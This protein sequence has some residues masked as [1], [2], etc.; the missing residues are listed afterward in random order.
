M[1]LNL[2]GSIG[3]ERT[4]EGRLRVIDT[5]IGTVDEFALSDDHWIWLDALLAGDTEL[6]EEAARDFVDAGIAVTVTDWSSALGSAAATLDRPIRYLDDRGSIDT[7]HAIKTLRDAHVVLIGAGGLGSRVA[8]SLAQCGIGHLTIID[9]D[10]VNAANLAVSA[11]YSASTVGQRKADSLAAFIASLDLGCQVDTA[12]ERITGPADLQPYA[13]GADLVIAAAN[14]PSA[15]TV[16][17]TV[18][19]A[20]AA[21]STAH[22]I[23]CG[24]GHAHSFFGMAVLPGTAP[25]WMCTQ[26]GVDDSTPLWGPNQIAGVWPPAPAFAAAAITTAACQ[27]LL[28]E[29]T[30]LQ[31]ALTAMD[32]A[33]MTVIK[34]SINDRC[35]TCRDETDD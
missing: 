6:P 21:T 20:C 22:L 15:A 17:R 2:R 24:Y 29:P 13:R 3:L 1:Q 30:P 14:E 5:A 11:C 4:H 8:V 35:P 12:H 23:G 10:T 25:C 16:G 31:G 18:A 32:L 9:D 19:T 26:V 33:S 28:G 27:M 7:L 34:Q